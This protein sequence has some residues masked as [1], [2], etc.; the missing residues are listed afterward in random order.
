MP[1]VAVPAA[2]LAGEVVE[3]AHL[4]L[5]PEVDDELVG[6]LVELGG[7]LGVPDGARAA[8]DGVGCPSVVAEVLA[9][10]AYQLGFLERYEVLVL[11]AV[12][13]LTGGGWNH[14]G[15]IPTSPGGR[16]R[17]VRGW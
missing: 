12:H 15:W 13:F 8:V 14:C 10:E 4:A 16:A 17:G 2:V 6:V 11:E 1:K 3:P 9:A 5:G 7:E